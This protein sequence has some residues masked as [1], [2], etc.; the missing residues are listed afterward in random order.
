MFFC[1]MAS[2]S[3]DIKFWVKVD[4]GVVQ[5]HPT[6]VKVGNDD[7][8]DDIIKKALLE[9]KLE[10]KINPSTVKAFKNDDTPVVVDVK[11]AD[12]LSEEIGTCAAN[13]LLLVCPEGMSKIVLTLRA[14]LVNETN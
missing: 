5:T 1:R 2:G 4:D 3:S 12:L 10:D 14:C 9:V 13:P 8:V 7:D 6:K 11:V